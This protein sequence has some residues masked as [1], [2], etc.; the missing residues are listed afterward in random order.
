L[1]TRSEQE[2]DM[3]EDALNASIRK[4]L[5]TFGV[6]AQRE[7]EGAVRRAIAEGRLAGRESL[8]VTA[9][10]AVDQIGLSHVIENTLELQ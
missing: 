9:T 6:T 7:I 1:V 4:F 8:H 3:N 5:R 2:L 10:L